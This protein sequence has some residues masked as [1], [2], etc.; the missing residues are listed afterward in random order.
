MLQVFVQREM[1]KIIVSFCCCLGNTTDDKHDVSSRQHMGKDKPIRSGA[2]CSCFQAQDIKPGT[3][4]ASKQV[5]VVLLYNRKP[6]MSH[7]LFRSKRISCVSVVH[8][9]YFIRRGGRT[10]E[11]AKGSWLV[12]EAKTP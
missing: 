12:D 8:T 4:M 5:S 2:Y 1:K 10:E 9:Q 11:V 7:F 3:I 6:Y